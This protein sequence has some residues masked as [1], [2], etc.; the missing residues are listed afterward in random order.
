MSPLSTN[1]STEAK[2]QSEDNSISINITENV[3]ASEI[4]NLISSFPRFSN[5]AVNEE[6]KSIKYTLQNYLYA[7]ESGNISGKKNTIRDLEKYYK[8]IQKLRK[9]LKKDEDDVLNR[10]L[11][12]LKTNVTVIEG[13]VNEKK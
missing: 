11:V 4:T 10:Y 2:I 8:N 12:R 9:Y 5:S 13:A 6:V 3:N 1:F 7:L